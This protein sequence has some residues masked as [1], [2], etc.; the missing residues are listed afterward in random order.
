MNPQIHK[1][2]YKRKYSLGRASSS[3]KVRSLI[4]EIRPKIFA[5]GLIRFGGDCDGGYL[6]PDDLKGINAIFSPGVGASSRFELELSAG[7]IPIYQVDATVDEPANGPTNVYFERKNLACIN[8]YDSIRLETW[9]TK[10]QPSSS[11]LLLQM[12]IEGAEYSVIL[13]TPISILNKFRIVLIE[14][15]A[16]DNLFNKHL[17]DLYRQVF[18]KLLETHVVVH[19]HPNNNDGMIALDGLEVPR[20]LEF[21]FLRKDRFIEGSKFIGFPHPADRTNNPQKK[22]IQPPRVWYSD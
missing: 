5:G 12:D 9:V 20:L 7:E 22:D 1:L 14:F 11:E 8:S 13:D 21:S 16:L 19:I 17:F 18:Q 2:L 15:H 10:Y 3:D 6:V 4:R